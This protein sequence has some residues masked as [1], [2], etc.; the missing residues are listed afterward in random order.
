MGQDDDAG[1]KPSDAEEAE[2]APAPKVRRAANKEEEDAAPKQEGE[3]QL[4]ANDLLATACKTMSGLKS[5]HAEGTITAGKAKASLKGDFGVGA[6]DMVVKGF[7]GKT[8]HRR[9]I[10]ESFWI[11]EDGKT[12]KEDAEPGMTATL[13]GIVTAPIGAEMKPWEQGEFTLVG[14]EKIGEETTLHVQKPA[15]GDDAAM[16]FWLASEEDTGVVIRKVSLTVSAPDGEFPISFTYTK[17][18]EE[19]KIEAP[20]SGKAKEE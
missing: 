9:S 6:V 8:A 5:Y 16:D 20:K 7:D 12:W 18:N 17:L 11:S 2:D 4:S 19:V 10:K 1:A 13:S 3:D 15:A 14:E